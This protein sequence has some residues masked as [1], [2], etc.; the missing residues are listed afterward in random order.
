MQART[1]SIFRLAGRIGGA[2]A[3]TL[4]LALWSAGT[5]F[6]VAA[7]PQDDA[8][9][10]KS[11]D[12]AAKKDAPKKAEAKRGLHIN[13]P[14]ALQGYTLLAPIMSTKTYLLDMQGRVVR[15]W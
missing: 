9:P 10:A 8:N 13:D 14:R 1:R 15:T 3:F 7:P 4:A 2:T 6:A 11:K 5:P 12:D